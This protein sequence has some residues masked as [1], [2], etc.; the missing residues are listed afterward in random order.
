V[1]TQFESQSGDV[2]STPVDVLETLVVAALAIVHVLRS[3]RALP[4]QLTATF[5]RLPTKN[6]GTCWSVT[7]RA[8]FWQETVAYAALS[9][10]LL[11]RRRL[12]LVG[13][14]THTWPPAQQGGG[15]GVRFWG[16]KE[17]GAAA[18]TGGVHASAVFWI[19]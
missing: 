12:A 4:P 5:V 10:S 16:N 19:D 15:L 7:D 3:E 8:P 14:E 1:H 13:L 11:H 17:V 9:H 18:A 2:I 6:P